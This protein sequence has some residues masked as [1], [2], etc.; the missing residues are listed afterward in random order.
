MNAESKPKTSPP[1]PAPRRA[2]SPP[3]PKKNP[4]TL[5]FV[6]GGGIVLGS[7]IMLGLYQV[8]KPA[9]R[10]LVLAKEF[11]DPVNYFSIQAPK[12]WNIDDRTVPGS[13]FIQGPREARFKPLIWIVPSMPAPGK[14]PK[15]V[16]EHKARL[17]IEEPSVKFLFE[18]TDSVDGCEA[19]RIEYECDYAEA[20]GAVPFKLKTLQ[21]ILK[22]PTYYA[23]YKITCSARADTFEIHR[24]A[25]EAS[26]RTFHRLPMPESKPRFLP[27]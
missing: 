6:I 9:P 21:F 4:Y 22:D 1:P 18:D 7:A 20:P 15:F 10:P 5:I 27:Q 25:F 23:Y 17:Q 19:V 11:R 8:F 24:A 14:L 12:N 26:A 2:W 3:A 16:V 13:V